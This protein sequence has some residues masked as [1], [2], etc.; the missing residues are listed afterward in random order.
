ML[1]RVCAVMLNKDILRTAYAYLNETEPFVKWN[2]PDADDVD[3]SVK[4]SKKHAAKCHPPE[5]TQSGRYLI[6]V[7]ERHHEGTLNL[8]ETMAHEMVH[9]HEFQACIPRTDGKHLHGKVFKAYAKQVC[10]AH[11]FDI[12]QF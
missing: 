6:E 12:A 3:F 9:I 8:M 10:E 11:G 2:L 5:C 4:D 7:A 1:G